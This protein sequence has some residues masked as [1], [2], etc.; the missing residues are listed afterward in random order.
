MLA[1]RYYLEALP[2][3]TN[4]AGVELLEIYLPIVHFSGD[5]PKES[6]RDRLLQ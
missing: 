6:L 3:V 4:V 1:G 5:T 2:P